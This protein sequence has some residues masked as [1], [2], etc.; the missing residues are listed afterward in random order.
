MPCP[1]TPKGLTSN[2][3]KRFKHL[4][5]KANKEQLPKLRN[6]VDNEIGKR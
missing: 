4:L 3:I 6:L 1:K 2:N 5:I